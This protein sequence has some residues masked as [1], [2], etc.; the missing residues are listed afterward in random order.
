LLM[1]QKFRVSRHATVTL[2]PATGTRVRPARCVA[3]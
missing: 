1:R 3:P 2:S